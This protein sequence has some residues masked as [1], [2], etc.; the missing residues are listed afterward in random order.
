MSYETSLPIVNMH[1][2]FDRL[3]RMFGEY[4]WNLDGNRAGWFLRIYPQIYG[5]ESVHVSKARLQ[6][7][8][9]EIFLEGVIE[10]LQVSRLDCT[11]KNTATA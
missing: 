6:P 10:G 11:N 9:M 3:M 7:K 5:A 4:N 2:Q 1:A 8:Q